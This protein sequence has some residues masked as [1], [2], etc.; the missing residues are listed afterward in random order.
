MSSWP[1]HLAIYE[2][3]TWVWLS[4]IGS[5]IGRPIQLSSVPAAEWDTIDEHRDEERHSFY[6]KLL[7]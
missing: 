7:D 1:R 2:I 6:E 3:N 4:S 5:T